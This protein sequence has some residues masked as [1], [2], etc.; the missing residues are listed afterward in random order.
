MFAYEAET[1]I[2]KSGCRLNVNVFT[3]ENHAIYIQRLCQSTVDMYSNNNNIIN[4]FA[5]ENL[6]SMNA[7]TVI[8]IGKLGR[9]INT[10]S[11][12]EL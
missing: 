7:S 12:D 4:K 1:V 3:I 5:F 10:K 9:K 2:G 11:N 6:G 8:L